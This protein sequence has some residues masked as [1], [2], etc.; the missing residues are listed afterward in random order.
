MSK[1]AKSVFTFGIYIM[2]VGFSLLI[3]PNFILELQ[4]FKPTSE[5]WIR[6]VG[7]LLTI[8]GCYY[9]LCARQE[10]TYFF[11]LTVYGRA[12]VIVF[13]SIF[14][15]LNLC[16]WELIILSVIDLAGAAWTAFA[17]Q[18]STKV[19]AIN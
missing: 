4:G 18:T 17:L 1:A 8:L 9:I 2:I 11:K 7:M 14:V 13:F 5:I 19:N 6:I 10:L 16:S 15:I 12:S 3:I